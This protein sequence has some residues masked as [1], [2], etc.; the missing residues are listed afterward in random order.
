[1][2]KSEMFKKI[3]KEQEMY[4]ID[5]SPYAR[6]TGFLNTGNYAINRILTGDIH[7]GIPMGRI[8]QLVGESQ[9]GKSLLAANIIINAI[10]SGEIDKCYYYDSEGGSC[11]S[12]IKNCIKNWDDNEPPVEITFVKDIQSFETK[13]TK[14]V[15]EC[16][17]AYSEYL[18]NP[19]ENDK[20][21]I[22][23]VVDS[24]GGLQSR[25]VED[26]IMKNGV[27][28]EDM[29][30]TPKL[31]KRV[32]TTM[33]TGAM[34]GNI[35]FVVIN[36]SY[37]T[38]EMYPSKIKQAAGGSGL[39]YYT[40]LKVQCEKSFI[41]AADDDFLTGVSGE[42]SGEKGFYKGTK[43]K[44]FTVKT[45]STVKPFFE[46]Q[47]YLDFNTG[48]SKYDG[49][50]EDAVKYGF[51]QDVRGGYICPSYSDKRITYRE[52]VSNDEIWNTFIEDFNK[53]SIEVMSYSNSM[54]KELADISNTM[55][56]EEEV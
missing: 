49:L 25:K 43:F 40:E 21:N 27:V 11:V 33:G 22:L 46:A 52:L 13:I 18:A 34:G 45:R 17:K 10:N 3:R 56:K 50:I 44:F 1:M 23:V 12:L 28:A 16:E 15:S 39:E 55:K 31:K 53:K 35:T 30:R 51:L 6:P 5:E 54:D 36:Y 2:K 7:K 48:L 41:K 14:L 9:S 38:A 29:M 4:S 32:A 19:K 24:F 37:S 20:I 47:V 26:D 42:E 8:T